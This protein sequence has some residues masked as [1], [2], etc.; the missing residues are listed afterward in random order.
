[1]DKQLENI[2]VDSLEPYEKLVYEVLTEGK[3]KTDRTGT[4][5]YSLFGKQI[6]YDL[7]DGF[8]LISTKKVNYNSVI[9]ELIWFLRGDTNINYLHDNKIKIWDEWAD[10]Y[11][12]LGSI[13]GSQWRQWYHVSDDYIKVNRIVDDCIDNLPVIDDSDEIVFSPKIKQ[14]W[15]DLVEEGFIGGDWNTFSVFYHDIKF[16]PGFNQ[17]YRS[18]NEFVL[19]PCYYGTDVVNKQSAIFIPMWYNNEL[20][21]ERGIVN[22]VVNKVKTIVSDDDN[23]VNADVLTRRKI[24]YDQI[25]D[26]INTIN[27]NPDSRRIILNAWNV[28]EIDNMALPPCHTMFQF[29]IEDGK[30]SGQLYQRSAD[31]FLGVPFNIASYS[32][33][34]HMVA[35]KT[36]LEVGEFVWTGG[37]CHIYSNHIEQVKTQ[38]SREHKGYPEISFANDPHTDLDKYEISDVIIKGYDPH[39]FIKGVVSV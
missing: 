10:D 11:G 27:N 8:P 34:I 29:Y 19:N 33:L 36:G 32:L 30:L 37:D 15:D 3:A 20:A 39:P 14:L 17:W 23:S 22:N 24:Y 31:L 18:E 9:G 1:M 38:L 35:R 4:G 25:D 7:N 28:A 26:I 6:R 13:Y 21:K 5:T 2:D 16:V 12:F